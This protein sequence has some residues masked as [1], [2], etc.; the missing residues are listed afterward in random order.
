VKSYGTITINGK[1]KRNG[2]ENLV[3]PLTTWREQIDGRY[4]FP[5]YSRAKDVLHS[6][7]GDVHIEEMIKLTNYKAVGPSK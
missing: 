7:D 1:H 2:E 5:T 6:S 3:P 4:W